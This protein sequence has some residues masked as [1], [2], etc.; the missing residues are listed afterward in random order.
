ML[1]QRLH[2]TQA[3]SNVKERLQKILAKGGLASRRNAEALI[4]QGRV[5]VNG[6]IVT[7]LGSQADA[8]ND[9]VEVDG[10]RVVMESRMYFLFHKPRGVVSTLSD[11][12]GRPTITDYLKPIPVRVFAVGRLDFATS[13]A[14]LLTNDGDFSD[15]L[16]HPRKSVPKTYVVKVQGLMKEADI[17]L[18]RT[19]VRLEDGVTKP[20]ELK[21]IRYET[22]KTWFELT[23]SEGRN[24]QIRRMGE[25][26]QFRVMRLARIAFAG[27]SSEGLRPGTLRPLT[28]DELMTLKKS[29]GVPKKISLAPD[30]LDLPVRAKP[31]G[32]GKRPTTRAPMREDNPRSTSTSAPRETS[33]RRG[34]NTHARSGGRGASGARSAE[35]QESGGRRNRQRSA[36]TTERVQRTQTYEPAEK[37]TRRRT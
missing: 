8:R 5:R 28:R 6:K 7:E 26:T 31:P 23:I 4:T 36:P 17:E 34:V 16:L 13:G 9:K 25:A 11:P 29:F 20:A 12:E 30:D 24:Q 35:P 2:A 37:K 33:G 19:G 10:K 18:W 21:I 27:V 14:L 32:F 22:D 15:T 1:A 3:Q